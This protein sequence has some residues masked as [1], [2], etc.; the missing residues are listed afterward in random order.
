MTSLHWSIDKVAYW[1]K[2]PFCVYRSSKPWMS[3]TLLWKPRNLQTVQNILLP[4]RFY[5][6]EF[7]KLLCLVLASGETSHFWNSTVNHVHLI[8]SQNSEISFQIENTV[9]ELI[10]TWLLLHSKDIQ[11]REAYYSFG[12]YYSI[13]HLSVTERSETILVMQCYPLLVLILLQD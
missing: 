8:L 5:V 12:N 1:V 13:R 2:T 7:R 6:H 4:C 10:K 11:I 9:S 3:T